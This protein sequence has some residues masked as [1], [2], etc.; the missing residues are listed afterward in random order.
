M[1][2][3]LLQDLLK[4]SS[5]KG[6]LGT[7]A[8]VFFCPVDAGFHGQPLPYATIPYGHKTAKIE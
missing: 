7:H 3:I 5:A 2:P 8:A 1:E 6:G 4:N